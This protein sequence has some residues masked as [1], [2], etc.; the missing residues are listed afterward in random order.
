MA[1]VWRVFK[2]IH[3]HILSNNERNYVVLPRV[4][5]L[6]LS[7]VF[8]APFLFTIFHGLFHQVSLFTFNAILAIL[9]IISPRT[10]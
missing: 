8:F 2:I 1:M 5:S 10:E 4:L 6:C 7:T 9:A 3:V